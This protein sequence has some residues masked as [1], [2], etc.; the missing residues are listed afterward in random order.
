MVVQF[1]N[2]L[3]GGNW[4]K[5]GN[6]IPKKRRSDLTF[7]FSICCSLV[8]RKTYP[9]P[10]RQH[11]YLF[12]LS[13]TPCSYLI[14]RCFLPPTF[15]LFVSQQGARLTHKICSLFCFAAIVIDQMDVDKA[16]RQV[17][18]SS[19]NHCHC[20]PPHTHTQQSTKVSERNK[21]NSLRSSFRNKQRHQQRQ[22]ILT[23]PSSTDLL[24]PTNKTDSGEANT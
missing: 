17:H 8:R 14:V 9:V 15:V 11:Q 19:C 2:H 23:K 6:G 10:R 1:A 7:V 16:R 13:R 12:E 5:L 22:E 21:T 18:Q 24:P 3:R 20:L 4:P